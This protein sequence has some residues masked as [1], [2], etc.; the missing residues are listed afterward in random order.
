MIRCFAFSE[1]SSPIRCPIF[2]AEISSASR[3]FCIDAFSS[4]FT[5]LIPGINDAIIVIA[6]TPPSTHLP[7]RSICFFFIRKTSLFVST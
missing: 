4:A 3:T 6:S 5:S 7:N 2:S 1:L